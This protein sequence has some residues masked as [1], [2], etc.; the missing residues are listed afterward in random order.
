MPLYSIVQAAGSQQGRASGA[1]STYRMLQ[2]ACDGL[3][4]QLGH[5]R[6][7]RVL[8]IPKRRS[9]EEARALLN[10]SSIDVRRSVR[11]IM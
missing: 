9:S 6:R 1:G 3:I 10:S 2:N 7:R 5:T 11:V 8:L 4:R